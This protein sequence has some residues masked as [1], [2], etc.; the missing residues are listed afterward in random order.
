MWDAD[1]ETL[2]RLRNLYSDADDMIEQG[3]SRR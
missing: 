1:A 3:S 2:S